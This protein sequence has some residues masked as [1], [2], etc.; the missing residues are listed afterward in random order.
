MAHKWTPSGDDDQH[1]SGDEPAPGQPGEQPGLRGPDS[2]VEER[3]PDAPTRLTRDS[4]RRVLRGTLREYKKDELGDRAA[5]LTYYG[6][7][8]L[9]PAL[10]VFVSLLG[11]TGHSTSQ[12]VIDSVRQLAPGAARDVLVKGIG[13]VQS[14][15]GLGS[16]L[17]VV[18]V[19]GALW[20]ASGYVAA[21]IRA[22]NAVYDVPEGRPAWKVLPIRVG[23]TL[24]L[25]LMACACGIILVFSGSVAKRAGDVVGLG[26][27]ALTA[28]SYAKWPVLVILVVLMIGLL[29]W[30]APNARTKGFAWVSTGSLLALLIWGVASAL[31]ALYVANFSSYN[32]TY[33]SLAA[34]IIFLVWLWLTNTAILL[35]LEFDAELH[36]ERAALGGFPR[37]REPYVRPRDTT[38][39]DDEGQQGS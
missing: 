35:G 8:A 23:V 15:A 3:A 21:F 25:L 28:W 31:F 24:A 33:G 32:K 11:V 38:K 39:A 17:A 29:Y 6:I 22:A 12:R 18:G 9:F 34:V 10:L 36:R 2:R 4:W 7:L 14:S 19:L 37:G 1:R 20:S 27:G 5:A 30:A 13:Q 26:G 16:V